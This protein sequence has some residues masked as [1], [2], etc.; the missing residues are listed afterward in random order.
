MLI[1]NDNTQLEI[2]TLI[3][4]INI[5]MKVPGCYL[6]VMESVVFKG[7]ASIWCALT[8]SVLGCR[9][10]TGTHTSAVFQQSKAH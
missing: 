5:R 8:F 9:E 10:L 6:S 3:E 7:R 2:E 1:K 4:I